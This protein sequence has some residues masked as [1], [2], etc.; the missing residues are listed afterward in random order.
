MFDDGIITLGDGAISV[1]GEMVSGSRQWVRDPRLHH[2]TDR[3]VEEL[4]R[5]AVT[6]S[7]CNPLPAGQKWCSECGYVKDKS[8]FPPDVRSF[9]GCA[10]KCHACDAARKRRDYAASVG[11]DVRAYQRRQG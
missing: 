5:R 9:D 2:P 8:D 11:R 10:A 3:M 1:D 7:P 4:F 6:I